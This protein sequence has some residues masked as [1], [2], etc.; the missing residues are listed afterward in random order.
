[1]SVAVIVCS[2]GGVTVELD[3]T[4]SRNV[5]VAFESAIEL[6][7][8]AMTKSKASATGKKRANI[9]VSVRWGRFGRRVVRQDAGGR[10]A[11]LDND[12]SLGGFHVGIGFDDQ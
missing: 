3:G 10:F 6:V 5:C 1:M 8:N 9:V 12:C 2:A 7:A 11:N 4:A